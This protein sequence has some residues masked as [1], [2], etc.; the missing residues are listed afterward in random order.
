MTDILKE[1][2]VTAPAK[3][4]LLQNSAS[5]FFTMVLLMPVMQHLNPDQVFSLIKTE[6]KGVT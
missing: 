4:I 3:Y 5:L 2:K 1:R 6:K